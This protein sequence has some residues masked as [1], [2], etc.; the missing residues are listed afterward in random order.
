MAKEKNSAE[1][2]DPTEA[3]QHNI[4]NKKI[5]TN[6]GLIS[7]RES[8]TVENEKIGNPFQNVYEKNEKNKKKYKHLKD[9]NIV[10]D[11]DPK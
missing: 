11:I 6:M 10:I 7:K 8:Q 5:D 9:E 1:P 4:D 3:D 2:S